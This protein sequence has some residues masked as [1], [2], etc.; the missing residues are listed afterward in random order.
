MVDSPKL[1]EGIIGSSPDLSKGPSLQACRTWGSSTS[2]PLRKPRGNRSRWTR[3]RTSHQRCLGHG[4]FGDDILFMSHFY[5]SLKDRT[6]VG[7]TAAGRQDTE[8]GV[9]TTGAVLVLWPALVSAT[10][11]VAC[12]LGRPHKKTPGPQECK[13]QSHPSYPVAP[14]SSFLV[15]GIYSGYH[16]VIHQEGI[17]FHHPSMGPPP[18]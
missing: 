7:I 10:Q 2:H 13:S 4:F 5:S 17:R 15:L 12:V 14:W 9:L 3:N 8:F 1:P 16:H 18:T 6:Q 11:V